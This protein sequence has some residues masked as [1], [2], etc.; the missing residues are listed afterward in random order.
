MKKRMLLLVAILLL[1][2][3]TNVQADEPPYRSFAYNPTG[4]PFYM[5]TPYEPVEIIGQSLYTRDETG[6]LTPVKG[7]T[8]PA[9]M[10]VD[11]DGNIYVADRGN[12]RIVKMD[13]AGVLLQEIGVG[14]LKAPEGVTVDEEGAVLVADTGNSRIAVFEK[15]GTVR[16]LLGAPKDKRLEGMMF[17]PIKVAVDQRDYIY[18]LLKGGNEGLMILSPD[19]KFQ[20]YFGRNATQVTFEERIKRIF[21]TKEQVAT[22]SNAVAPSITGMYI[23]D[24]GYVYTCTNNLTNGQ[25]K[26]FNASG[27]DLFAKVETQVI[28]DRRDGLKSAVSSMYVDKDG[29]IYAVDNTN[30]T[31]ILFDATGKPLML[32]GEKLQGNERRIGY[33]SD[34]VAISAREDGTLMVLDRT[35]NGIHVFRPTTLMKNIL[36]NVSLYNDGKYMES[37]EGWQD[38]LKANTSYYWANLG[39]G[40]IAYTQ[41]DWTGAMDQMRQALNQEY[42][43]D[44]LWK[45]R[46]EV[47]QQY[48]GIVLG[49]LIAVAAVHFILVKTLHFNAFS[50]I[51]KGLKAAKNA[52]I[53]P[54]QKRI[55]YLNVLGGHLA[56]SRRV[57]RHPVDT[58]YETTRRNQGSVASAIVLYVIFLV[59]MLGERALTNF[60]FDM[61]GIRGV[62]LFSFLLTYI[63]P[64]V[65]WVAANYLVGA[66]TKGQGTLRG[67]FISTIYAL[68]PLIVFTIPIALISN[69][70]TLAEGSIFWIARTIIYLWV[71]LLL[72]LQV[73]EIHGY[74][75][76]ETIKNI[77]WIF[78]VAAMAVVG[79]LAVSGILV[80]AYNFLNE[81]IRELL[82]YV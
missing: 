30:G 60:V 19:G 9:D 82:G 51:K 77:L 79:V 65:L 2:G 48:A 38:I 66:I 47:V 49:V 57:L 67:I 52:V 68:M 31:V 41:K 6:D 18:V 76:G 56:F 74:E 10:F 36:A 71:A 22:N 34:P 26:K 14:T 46:A 23:G 43:S 64:V 81:F 59:V 7:L 50:W 29:V 45:Y 4:W 62:S 70:L 32:F 73:K 78:F 11:G 27:V 5:Q 37:Q 17:T 58:Y 53:V 20:G 13:A 3:M 80:Q 72:F 40:K 1:L 39:L 24:T 25:I 35:Y 63:A 42:Y 33:F 55:P 61:E 21:Y 28:V 54:L 16:S 12:N 15:D 8:N 69:V 44:A 75:F